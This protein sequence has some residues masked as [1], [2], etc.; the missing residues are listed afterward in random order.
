MGLYRQDKNEQCRVLALMTEYGE[1][2]QP[3]DENATGF[4][5]FRV[6]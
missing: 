4:E 2:R 6:G 3:L 5:R 1:P